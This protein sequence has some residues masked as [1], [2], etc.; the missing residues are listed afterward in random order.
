MLKICAGER[1]QNARW[2]ACV[3]IALTRRKVQGEACARRSAARRERGEPHGPCCSDARHPQATEAANSAARRVVAPP[4]RVQ[5]RRFVRWMW[6]AHY[7]S[8]SVVYDRFYAGRNSGDD[9]IS[10]RLLRDLAV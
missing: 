1:G 7:L 10:S 8:A 9:P 3:S 2:P 4:G 6:R 5:R